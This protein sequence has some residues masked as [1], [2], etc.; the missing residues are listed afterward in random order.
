MNKKL[1]HKYD[2]A[3]IVKAVEEFAK[4]EFSKLNNGY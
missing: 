4:E 2:G 3:V 1:K